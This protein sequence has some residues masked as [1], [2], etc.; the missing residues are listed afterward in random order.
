MKKLLSEIYLIPNLISLFRLLLFIP[1][2]ILFNLMNSDFTYRYYILAL[3][4]LAFISDLLDGFIARKTNQISELGKIIDPVADKT[5]MAI[6][7]MNLF[8]MEII[9]AYYFWIVIMRDVLIFL[10]GI[11][12]SKKIGKVLPSNRLGKI[13]VFSIGL[14]IIL[15]LAMD[16]RDSFIYEA[17]MN[18]S[19]IL[20]F[21]SLIGYV[22]R[23]LE[24]LKWKKNETV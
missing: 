24:L 22:I 8:L 19:L 9:P 2:L 17:V 16:N 11:A 14:F 1:F 20:C 4:A 12:L 3:I 23:A 13:T 18:I 15:S 21:A 10:G 7:V 6:I 5:L